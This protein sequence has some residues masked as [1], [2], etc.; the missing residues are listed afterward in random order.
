MFEALRG[1]GIQILLGV[2]DANIEEL[3]QSYT[4]AND[5]VEKN[6]RSYYPDVHFRYIAVGNEAIPS[7]YASFVLPAIKNL[8]SA[9][10]YGELWQRIKVIAIISPSALIVFPTIYLIFKNR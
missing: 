5:W 4:A 1:S 10:S 3:A 7:S 9:L 8:H 6:I 2:N